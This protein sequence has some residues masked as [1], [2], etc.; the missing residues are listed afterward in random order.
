MPNKADNVCGLLLAGDTLFLGGCRDVVPEDDPAAAYEGRAESALWDVSAANGERI[1]EW[2]LDAPPVND[3]IS[4]AQGR[5]YISSTD[6][7][8]LCLIAE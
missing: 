4:A 7:T 3:G 2:E 1:V 8:V 6:G 5:L